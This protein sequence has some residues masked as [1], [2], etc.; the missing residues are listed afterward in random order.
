MRRGVPPSERTSAGFQGGQRPAS[1][2]GV[3]GEF[4]FHTPTSAQPWNLQRRREPGD[5]P[6]VVR[7]EQYRA[8]GAVEA[9][10]ATLL[11]LRPYSPDLNP[12]LGRHLPAE[13]AR[14]LGHRG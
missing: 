2:A 12:P 4:L 14:R 6:A 9:S 3:A 13:C 1:Q 7:G 10:G 5:G 8:R 11:H